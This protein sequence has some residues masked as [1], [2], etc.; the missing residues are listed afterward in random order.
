MGEPVTA[1]ERQEIA[2]LLGLGFSQHETAKLLNRAQSTVSRVAA[3][4]GIESN[5]PAPEAAVQARRARR[6]ASWD[7]ALE[8]ISEKLKDDTLSARDVRELCVAL[9]V[10]E[11]KCRQA[12]R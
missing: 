1:D 10:V 7:Q 2:G 6:A 5:H 3:D 11:D 4:E 8:V 12:E 9:A